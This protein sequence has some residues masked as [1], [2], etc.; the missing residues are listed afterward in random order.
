MVHADKCGVGKS[1]LVEKLTLGTGR[2]SSS[3][4]N[5]VSPKKQKPLIAPKP[6]Q[7]HTRDQIDGNQRTSAISENLFETPPGICLNYL[8]IQR[9]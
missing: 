8:I 1:T 9:I 2:S 7:D 3:S 5:L 6:K 4:S